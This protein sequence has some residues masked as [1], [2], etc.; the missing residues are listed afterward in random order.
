M[1]RSIIVC[2]L[3][4][5]LCSSLVFGQIVTNTNQSAQY[6]RMLARNASTDIDAAYYNPA[7]LARLTDGWHF[8]LSNQ[9]IFQEKTVTNEFPLLNQPEFV[10]EVNVPF[11]PNVYAAYKTGKLV[12]SFGFGPNS[13]GGTADFSSGL[14]SFE[15]PISQ[16]PM[17]MTQMGLPTTEYNA[18]IAFKGTSVFLGFQLNASYALSDVLSVAGGMRYISA[19]N[20]YEGRIENIEFNPY[21]P[22]LK[23]NTD[24]ISAYQFFS[25][26]GL[27]EYAG[28]VTDKQVNA[29]QT[30]S[31]ITPILGLNFN[32]GTHLNIGVRYEFNTPL[33]LQN[34]TTVDDT[35]LFPDGHTF[36]NDIPAIFSV[37]AEYMLTRRLNAFISYNQFFEKQA[38]LN[39][40]EEWLDSNTYDLAL[41]L[42]YMLSQTVAVSGGYM[43]TRPGVSKEYQNDFSHE[44]PANSIAFGSRIGLTPR[45]NLDLGVLLVDYLDAS[46]EFTYPGVGTFS[47]TYSRSTWAFSIGIAYR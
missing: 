2:A 13:G 45:L 27:T 21:H 42:E 23:P 28:M 34:Q 43:M 5:C 9:T 24:M 3:G 40:A 22:Y 46:R 11:F 32:F 25:A 7:G 39:G 16:L 29:E 14:P 41:A 4:L 1:K 36:R 31:G 35:G 20:T 8:S 33:E 18:D 44:I 26:I 10:G 38:D 19:A 12:F 47:E 30:G 15:I 6:L 17:M 37:G